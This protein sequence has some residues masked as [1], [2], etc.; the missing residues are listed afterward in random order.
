LMATPLYLFGKSL[1]TIP[2]ILP[3]ALAVVVFNIL[4]IIALRYLQLGIERRSETPVI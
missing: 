1:A 3:N 4:A 2:D